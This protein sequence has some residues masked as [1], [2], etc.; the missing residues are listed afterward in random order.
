MTNTKSIVA[1]AVFAAIMASVPLLTQEAEATVVVNE[2]Y[3]GVGFDVVVGLIIADIIF[4]ALLKWSSDPIKKAYHVQNIATH[5]AGHVVGLDDLYD[6]VYSELTMYGYSK[7]GETK[8]VDLQEGDVLGTQDLY[9][10]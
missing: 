5:E 8:K 6:E 1:I 7:K 4:N 3:N 9:G 2:H 10:E